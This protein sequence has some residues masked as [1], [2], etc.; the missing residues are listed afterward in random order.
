MYILKIKID[1]FWAVYCFLIWTKFHTT[2]TRK[3]TKYYL[4][5]YVL[6]PHVSSVIRHSD[7]LL[8]ASWP[9]TNIAVVDDINKSIQKRTQNSSEDSWSHIT[10]NPRVTIR[11]HYLRL[12]LCVQ[13]DI[14]YP[15]TASITSPKNTTEQFY[16]DGKKKSLLENWHSSLLTLPNSI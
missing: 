3:N 10:A 4:T 16:D 6:V 11:N 15:E 9:A 8:S 7:Y 14:R 5:W 2:R 1:Q 13:K 12:F